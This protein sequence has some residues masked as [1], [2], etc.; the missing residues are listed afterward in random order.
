MDT[1]NHKFKMAKVDPQF[2]EKIKQ[3]ALERIKNDMDKQVNNEQ[4]SVRRFTKAMTRYDPLWKILK[5]AQF[6]E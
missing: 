4:A 1:K 5:E 6:I 2:I 3:T